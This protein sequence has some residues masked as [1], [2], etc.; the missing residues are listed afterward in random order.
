M[1][2]VDR[3][4]PMVAEMIEALSDQIRYLI[5]TIQ[6]VVP[7]SLEVDNLR[8]Y[9][10]LLN[11]RFHNKVQFTFNCV[12][13]A[14][15]MVPKLILQPLVENAFIHGIKPK[16]GPG[17]IQLTA[18]QVRNNLVISVMDN[19]VGMA[20]EEVD[21]LCELLA[22]DQPGRKNDY[23]W[24]SIG[25]K[26]VHDRLQYLYGESYGLSLFSTPGVGTII[27]AVLPYRLEQEPIP[28]PQ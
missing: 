20:Q 9:V 10:Y 1:T 24:A 28:S 15:V 8:K 23:E 16:N 25:L 27:K 2:A 18:L 7:L 4:D 11:C 12:G 22:S 13:S 3:K 5:G 6:D 17:H 26:N 19:G 21:R 14:R